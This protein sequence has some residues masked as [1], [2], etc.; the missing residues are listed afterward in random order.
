MSSFYCGLDVFC[1]FKAIVQ[2]YEELFSVVQCPLCSPQLV[3]GR[4]CVS[5]IGT[6]VSNR[7]NTAS[8]KYNDDISLLISL[9][10][11]SGSINHNIRI[12]TSACIHNMSLVTFAMVA[13][14]LNSK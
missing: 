9:Y 13:N 12:K 2:E 8:I 6:L 14:T 1:Q 10:L 11:I 7:Q 3:G 4:R 5:N